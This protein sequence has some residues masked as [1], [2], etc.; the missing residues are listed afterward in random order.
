MGI[1]GN[2]KLNVALNKAES[3]AYEETQERRH[4]AAA[5]A[6]YKSAASFLDLLNASL[7]AQSVGRDSKPI[8][9]AADDIAPLRPDQEQMARDQRRIKERLTEMLVAQKDAI[10]S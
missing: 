3:V 10:G 8:M 5:A 1:A 4:E 6:R 2:S 9:L 7:R